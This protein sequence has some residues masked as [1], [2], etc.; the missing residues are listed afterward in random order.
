M[1]TN[2]FH[3]YRDEPSFETVSTLAENLDERIATAAPETANEYM[4][5]AAQSILS[6]LTWKDFDR[7]GPRT[8]HD[9][10]FVIFHFERP[11]VKVRVSGDYQTDGP[12]QEST[13]QVVF[14]T[15]S[16]NESVR[17]AVAPNGSIELQ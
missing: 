15:E 3:T 4:T 6:G 16:N 7:R 8:M 17:F 1:D 11:S 5:E 13:I 10:T 9:T 2:L 12:L 14:K